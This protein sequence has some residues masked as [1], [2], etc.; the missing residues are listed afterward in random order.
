[1]SGGPLEFREQR[2]FVSHAPSPGE[3][4]FG[5]R[6]D[7]LY[8]AKAHLMIAGGRDAADVLQQEVAEALYV[9]HVL[10]RSR[11]PGRCS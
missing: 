10:Y 1:V 4:A 5:G 9:G 6:V 7:R 3:E 8:H 11:F 2:R